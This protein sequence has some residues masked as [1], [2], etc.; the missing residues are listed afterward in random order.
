[1][2]VSGDEG[3]Q[4]Q[5]GQPIGLYDYSIRSI[6]NRRTCFCLFVS[7]L[8]LFRVNPNPN[9]DGNIVLRPRGDTPNKISPPQHALRTA[10]PWHLQDS[11][12]LRSLCARISHPFIL[13]AHLHC[14]H[15]CDTIARLLRNTRPPSDLPCVCHTPYNIS[16]DNIM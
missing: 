15:D 14:P 6:L 2:S 10:S 5:G 3:S 4:G 9:P 1:V 8:F 16:N 11:V 12:S 7:H 13:P